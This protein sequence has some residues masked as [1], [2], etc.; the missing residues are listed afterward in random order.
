MLR[1]SSSSALVHAV[2]RK[3]AVEVDTRKEFRKVDFCSYS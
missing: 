1:P 3:Q 2:F